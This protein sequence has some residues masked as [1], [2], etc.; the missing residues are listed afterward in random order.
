MIII[1]LL[2]YPQLGKYTIQKPG[3]IDLPS[4]EASNNIL[5]NYCH[6]MSSNVRINTFGTIN[7]TFALDVVGQSRYTSGAWGSGSQDRV[8]N[9]TVHADLSTC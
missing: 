4:I 6:F 1:D 8:K 9:N 7:T 3:N 2:I 5:R